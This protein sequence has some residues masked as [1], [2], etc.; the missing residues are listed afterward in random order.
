MSKRTCAFCGTSFD[1]GA[2]W[3]G[4]RFRYCSSECAKKA[5]QKISIIWNI[6]NATKHR[7]ITRNYRQ[8]LKEEKQ[9]RL[10]KMNS[11]LKWAIVP[12]PKRLSKL[13]IP[14]SDMGRSLGVSPNIAMALKKGRWPT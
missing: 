12:H 13:A 9:L 6:N 2:P 11:H 14:P 3:Q 10:D 4:Q 5:S 8:R 1:G 7:N